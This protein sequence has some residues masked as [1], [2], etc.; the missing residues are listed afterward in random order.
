M[1]SLVLLGILLGLNINPL[2]A[3]DTNY[4]LGTHL[5]AEDFANNLTVINNNPNA[6][7][8]KAIDAGD[9]GSITY[10]VNMESEGEYRLAI[11]YYTGGSNPKIKVKINDGSE[12][13]YALDVF[14][15]WCKDTRRLPIAKDINVNLK[16]G[17]NTITVK[18]SGPW[19]NFD[20]IAIFNLNDPYED[21][22]MYNY[23]EANG[24]RIQAE[25]CRE[26]NGNYSDKNIRIADGGSGTDGFLLSVD[27]DYL[28]KPGWVVN[29][30]EAGEYTLQVAYYGADSSSATYKWNING[31]DN[32]LEFPACPANWNNNSYSSKAEFKVNLKEGKNTIYY[33]Y[34][35]KGYIDFDWF[36]LF[37]KEVK[38]DEKI[39]AEDYI[40]GDVNAQ[41]GIDKYSFVSNYV[42]EIAKGKVS[43][44]I[45]VTEAGNYSLFT[46]TYTETNGAYQYIDINGSKTKL[47]YKNE[48]V[49]GWIDNVLESSLNRFNIEL[50]EGINHIEISKGNDDIPYNYVDLDFMYITKGMIDTS[51]LDIDFATT[52]EIDLST[53]IDLP[54]DYEV[55]SL[56]EDIV[57]IEN[58][59]I[60]VVSSGKTNIEVCYNYAGYSIVERIRVNINKLQYEGNDLVAKDTTKTYTGESILVDVEMPEGWSFKQDKSYIDVGTYEVTVT[61]THPTYEE[62]TQK[63]NLTITKAI[64]TGD[65]LI[66]Q[67][68][69]YEY[70]ENVK[71]IIASCP[72]DWTIE[73]VNNGQTEK[74]EYEVTVI[75][76]NPNYETVEKTVTLTIKGGSIV[77]PIIIGSVAL[78]AIGATSFIIIKKKKK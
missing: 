29:A 12:T 58:N 7:N 14:N 72:N 70:D 42:V 19:V 41:K 55:K 75:F 76:T 15:G 49:N 36:R 52:K 5:E 63:V 44:D 24:D 23:L 26:V 74:G 54:F 25:W 68:M 2:N 62:V 45:S 11:G 9:N 77:L 1:K 56:N 20:Y 61:F 33:S 46:S 73:Y 34:D 6:S 38:L 64:Y 40:I 32:N 28:S 57:K 18:A 13:E 31:V 39:E 67:D 3:N 60:K 50:N 66:A 8:K 22:E 53:L 16:Q 48:K 17:K 47:E 30:S 37:K 27:D 69:T 78:V 51:N 4:I 43:F 35:K 21:Y 59:K 71:S 10:E 65:E